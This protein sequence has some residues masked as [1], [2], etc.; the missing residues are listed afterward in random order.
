MEKLWGI[1]DSLFPATKVKNGGNKTIE[2]AGLERRHWTNAGP[3]PAVFK[4]A[5]ISAGLPSFNPH[6]FRETLVKLGQEVCNI[7]EE[8]RARS[9]NLGHEEVLTTFRN[10]GS[11]EAGRQ[12]T[13]IK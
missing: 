2:A 9:Q 8:F 10:Y 7:P 3:I 1:D 6:S 4:S 11:I 12:A 5:F 13:I